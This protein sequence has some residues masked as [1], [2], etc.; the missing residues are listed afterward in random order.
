MCLPFAILAAP[1]VEE[2]HGTDAQFQQVL[3]PEATDICSRSRVDT[4][5]RCS[6]DIMERRGSPEGAC[7]QEAHA[8]QKIFA[9]SL[10]ERTLAVNPTLRSPGY[11]VLQNLK[12]TD[13]EVNNMIRRWL[14]LNT[15]RY[16][17]DAREA[18]CGWM[19]E[20]MDAMLDFI[21]QGYPRVLSKQSSYD[22]GYLYAAQAVASFTVLVVLVST[23]F[24]FFYRK[25][26]VFVFAQ[27]YFC[28]LIL[29]GFFLICI[30][31]IVT[32]LNPSR[33]SCTARVWLITLGYTIELVPLLVKIAAINSILQSA[34]KMRRVQISPKNMML[35]VAVVVVAVTAYLLQWTIWD[36]PSEREYFRLKSEQ[37]PIVLSSL[38]CSSER[39]DHW[40]LI[41][42]GWQSVMLI[43]ASVLAYQSRT[44]LQEFNESRSLGTMA[45]SHFLFV[46]L[47]TIL[48]FLG[49]QPEDS[50]STSSGGATFEPNVVSAASS[51]LLSLDALFA[52]TI[53]ILPKFMEA[54]V[55]PEVY[56]P[57][58]GQ[59]VLRNSV[60]TQ[61]AARGGMPSAAMSNISMIESRAAAARQSITRS[62]I[63]SDFGGPSGESTKKAHP[64]RDGDRSWLFK[65]GGSGGG[66]MQSS[67]DST[68]FD[69]PSSGKRSSINRISQVKEVSCETTSE[70]DITSRPLSRAPSSQRKLNVADE[71]YG[72]PLTEEPLVEENNEDEEVE[73]DSETCEPELVGGGDVE[74]CNEETGRASERVEFD[75]DVP[76]RLSSLK[77]IP[78]LDSD[79]P[80]MIDGHNSMGSVDSTEEHDIGGPQ[81]S[82]PELNVQLNRSCRTI[83]PHGK[84][85][86]S[87]GGRGGGLAGRLFNRSSPSLSG[88]SKRSMVRVP[89]FTPVLPV[90]RSPKPSSNRLKNS[91]KDSCGNDSSRL[92]S[93]SADVSLPAEP[94][95]NDVS[96]ESSDVTGSQHLE[97]ASP[98]PPSPKPDSEDELT[99]PPQH[100]PK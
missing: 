7:D 89:S 61:G 32:T 22:T 4:E 68:P 17:N 74:I 3:L 49:R 18:V 96:I 31:S 70:H 53:Y 94:K 99:L 39:F 16:G 26:K 51:F 14:A 81:W 34:K 60:A 95:V 58:R 52:M 2:F 46:V 12:I 75:R 30:G 76:L 41:T 100:P 65:L 71:D 82:K 66:S 24:T 93:S 59:S 55:S 54:K 98:L 11:T 84:G 50:S 73:K 86:F 10:R 33:A 25:T 38:A 57:K 5:A 23:A 88:S 6:E 64:S 1:V 56:D 28:W 35:R 27:V 45:Y 67:S 90:I 15:D 62:G 63:F 21:P 44:V 69:S 79:D 97:G 8:L 91:A 87:G 43:M 48:L 78:Q 9:K 85:A 13:L 80:E 37:S 40:Y 36:T 29:F 19:V 72:V 47:R 42:L 77:S 92:N 83:D 20:N